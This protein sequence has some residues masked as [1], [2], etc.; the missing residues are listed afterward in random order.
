MGINKQLSSLRKRVQGEP[1]SVEDER[2]LQLFW[3]RVELKKEFARLQDDN[4][5][6]TQQ[7]KKLDTAFQ[8]GQLRLQQLEEFLGDPQH[9]AAALVY[10]QLRSLWL[11]ASKRLAELCVELTEQQQQRERK[12]QQIEFDQNRQHRVGE[13]EKS[14]LDMRSQWD[15]LN[16]RSDILQRQLQGLRWFWHRK[17]QQTLRMQLAPIDVERTRVGT[18]LLALEQQRDVLTEAMV[19]EFNGLTVEG[20]RLVNTAVLAYAQQLLAWLGNDGLAL[21][22]K[23]ASVRQVNDVQYGSAHDCQ[24]WLEKLQQALQTLR[25]RPR[26]LQ[27]LKQQTQRLRSNA[28]YRSDHETVPVPESIGTVPVHGYVSVSEATPAPM[29]EDINV[30]L[31]DYWELYSVL[32]H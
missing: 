21:M 15:S 29:M 8:Q 7:L 30:L 18:E 12:L 20:R 28:F 11:Q 24:H 22:A 9:G 5:S 32:Q 23:E 26:D 1:A 10:Y 16:A 13:M 17:K 31:D 3:N 25:E 19:P 27:Q 6:L 2:L 14:I 4:Y